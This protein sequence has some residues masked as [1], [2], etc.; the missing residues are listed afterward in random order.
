[1]FGCRCVT[2]R[3]ACVNLEGRTR[4]G[5]IVVSI[6]QKCTQYCNQMFTTICLC[7]CC[8]FSFSRLLVFIV[9]LLCT[10]GRRVCTNAVSYPVKHTHTHPY[11]FTPNLRCNLRASKMCS[12]QMYSSSC[13][14][15]LLCCFLSTSLFLTRKILPLFSHSSCVLFSPFSLSLSIYFLLTLSFSQTT[16]SNV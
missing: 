16:N 2:T 10:H 15:L 9:D 8:F 11:T 13:F 4:S 3:I 6:A 7:N 14:F 12:S 5:V 1:M